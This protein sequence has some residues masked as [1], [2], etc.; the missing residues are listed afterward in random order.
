[1]VYYLDFQEEL[2]LFLLERRVDLR[3]KNI[4][5]VSHRSRVEKF[6]GQNFDNMYLPCKIAFF[7]VIS[8]LKKRQTFTYTATRFP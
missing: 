5:S 8:S 4:S 6:A 1:M 7:S 2:S 3:V